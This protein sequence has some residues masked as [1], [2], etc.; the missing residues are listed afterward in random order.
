MLMEDFQV[1]HAH[2]LMSFKGGVSFGDIKT[3]P[4][5]HLLKTSLSVISEPPG[6]VILDLLILIGED[7]VPSDDHLLVLIAS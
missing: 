6:I 7:F 2:F 1:L 3:L 5:K 4:T